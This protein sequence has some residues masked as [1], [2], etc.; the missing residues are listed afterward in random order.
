MTISD[1]LTWITASGTLFENTGSGVVWNGSLFVAMGSDY[2]TGGNTILTSADGIT[3]STITGTTFTTAGTS[4]A[5]NGQ[6]FI[7]VGAG[8]DTILTSLN[9]TVW[10]TVSGTTFTS[11]G[12]T[13]SWNGERWIA[14]GAGT[15]I[16]LTSLDGTSW[17]NTLSQ[18]TNF[19]IVGL[20]VASRYLLPESTSYSSKTSTC[21]T[22]Y[23]T[24]SQTLT[25]GTAA[26]V[27]HDVIGFSYGITT[28]TGA[29]GSF[30]VP[31][32]GIYKI[33]PSL[34]VL[35]GGNGSITIWIKVN[36][37][38]V[39]DTATLTL[40]KNGE[41]SVVT[42]EYLLELQGGDSVQVW[43]RAASANCDVHYIVSGGTSPNDYP[44]A[45]GVITNM[46]RIA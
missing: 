44:A 5:W 23:S 10:A 36:S 46:Y 26:L 45:P 16:L 15:D 40:F 9:G 27:L 20:G 14:L 39:P 41:E 1:G 22:A 32:T 34:Q 6:R 30:T 35:G 28:T 13:V 24:A 21:A 25:A 37:V 2:P 43:A 18:G 7:A 12:N 33:I 38:N 4:V 17:T 31:T 19:N 42:C 8:S 29:S 3:W 11:H